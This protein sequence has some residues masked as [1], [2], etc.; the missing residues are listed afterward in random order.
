VRAG[1]SAAADPIFRRAVA[2][3]SSSSSSSNGAGGSG[4]AVV[5]T[6]PYPGGGSGGIVV[7]TANPPSLRRI[8]DAQRAK[9]DFAYHRNGG[10]GNGGNGNNNK[11]P[12]LYGGSG[13]GCGGGTGPAPDRPN[14]EDYYFQQQQQR[15][16]PPPPPGFS[17]QSSGGGEGG[18]L[19]G[20]TTTTTGLWSN[21]VTSSSPP[22]YYYYYENQSTTGSG[23]NSCTANNLNNGI[24]SV[25]PPDPTA[26]GDYPTYRQRQ[27]R[28]RS[29]EAAWGQQ[30]QPQQPF[31]TGLPHQPQEYAD[32]SAEFQFDGFQR[33]EYPPEQLQQQQEHPEWQHYEPV[34][35]LSLPARKHDDSVPELDGSFEEEWPDDLYVG[36]QQQQPNDLLPIR[37]FTDGSGGATSDRADG[38]PPFDQQLQQEQWSEPAF[39]P[40][41][42]SSSSR[43]DVG[44]RRFSDRH[45]PSSEPSNRSAERDGIDRFQ[46]PT[47]RKQDGTFGDI[48]NYAPICQSAAPSC[49]PHA[50]RSGSSRADDLSE[51]DFFGDGTNVAPPIQRDAPSRRFQVSRPKGSRAGDTSKD[52]LAGNVTNYAPPSRKEAPSNQSQVPIL[53]K[54]RAD[55]GRKAQQ[56]VLPE[57]SVG[58]KT[59]R[60]EDDRQTQ[61]AALET[62][63]DPNSSETSMERRTQP[64]SPEASAVLQGSRADDSR[65][66]QP[67]VPESAA[68]GPHEEQS[69][70]PEEDDWETYSPKHALEQYPCFKAAV[71][72]IRFWN[73]GVEVDIRGR[74]IKAGNEDAPPTASGVSQ[75]ETDANE[76][77]HKS[78][79]GDDDESDESDLDA[80]DF[81]GL[82][83]LWGDR[84]A[85]KAKENP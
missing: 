55:S 57:S 11:R 65:R 81:K 26:G 53:Q 2:A 46:K 63:A 20:A 16:M 56:P 67:A 69:L 44:I 83:S 14:R 66:T 59:A 21:G 62:S 4:T 73:N 60:V 52:S 8:R 34:Q 78:I 82:S 64:A 27:L 38:V 70:T 85:T 5:G 10:G 1:Q 15:G 79:R 7:G 75:Q 71:S 28:R 76:N 19:L 9:L 23:Q 61:T 29:F 58:P 30:Q 54:S 41:V 31:P 48:T 47:E 24:S 3:T 25:P 50:P 17:A 43:C 6:N 49:R 32:P 42:A 39:P 72:G 35:G 74:P 51:D 13:S 84:G 22:P 77:H 37:R 80:D 18:G 36:E 12:R 68:V 45:D 40:P 33:F